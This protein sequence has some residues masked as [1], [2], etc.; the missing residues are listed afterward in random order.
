MTSPTKTQKPR[1]LPWITYSE[2]VDRQIRQH[3]GDTRTPRI[4]N[5]APTYRSGSD[6]YTVGY[7][8]ERNYSRPAPVR[9]DVPVASDKQVNYIKDLMIKRECAKLTDDV[10][11]GIF[12]DKAQATRFITFLL[13]QPLRERSAPI[14][15][16]T[17]APVAPVRTRLNFAEI[18][19]GNYA[20]RVDGVVKFYRVSTSK[21]GYKNVQVRASD[22]LYMQ[23]GKAG[24]AIL[25]RIVEAGLEAS[26]MLFAEELGRCWKCGKTLT[27]E[28]SRARGMGP[29]CAG[30]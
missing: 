4:V 13:S 29:D 3:A 24:I 25:H 15:E 16:P 17:P 9:T 18:L 22:A 20:I 6:S 26:R 30:K 5:G 2:A 19:D 1:N 7:G 11:E 8:G 27:D 23:Y 12:A 14:A 10:L 21:S 28:D